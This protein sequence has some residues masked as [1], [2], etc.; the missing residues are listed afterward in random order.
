M[1]SD[2]PTPVRPP[3]ASRWLSIR[4]IADDLGVSTSTTYKWSARGAPWFP[5]AI[6]LRNGDIRV[7]RDLYEAWL[8]SLEQIHDLGESRRAGEGHA[9]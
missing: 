7:R 5:R 6:R 2:S 3:G 8:K 1:P 4:Q 9:G